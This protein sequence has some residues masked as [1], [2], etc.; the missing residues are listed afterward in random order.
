MTS[1]T[2]TLVLGIA[3]VPFGGFRIWLATRPGT[4]QRRHHLVAGVA[5]ALSGAFLIATARGLVHF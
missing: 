3:L 4:K 5:F 2:V 1:Q